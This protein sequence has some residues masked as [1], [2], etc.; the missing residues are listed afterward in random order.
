MKTFIT[1]FALSLISSVAF[2]D[3]KCEGTLDDGQKLT[4]IIRDDIASSDP[5]TVEIKIGDKQQTFHEVMNVW[6]GH[7]KGLM[8]ARGLSISYGAGDGWPRDVIF[9]ALIDEHIH[10]AT[11]PQCQYNSLQ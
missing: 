6:D 5:K 10:T 4:L 11:I 8:T 9:T 3:T 1:L 7:T 2:A